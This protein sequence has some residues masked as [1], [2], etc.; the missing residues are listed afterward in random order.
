VSKQYFGTI[1]SAGRILSGM[2]CQDIDRPTEYMIH[3]W[4]D[5]INAMAVLFDGAPCDDGSTELTPRLLFGVAEK[6][7]IFIVDVPEAD[8]E[9]FNSLRANF[10]LTHDGA[11]VGTW[12]NSEGEGGPVRFAPSTAV[13]VNAT[14][15]DDWASFATWANTMRKEKNAGYF[16]GHGSNGFR[17]ETTL[18][19]N[20]Y[21][22][23]DRYCAD[24]LQKFHRHAEAAL[25]ER[26]SLND[27]GDYSML[28]GLAQHFG[29]PTPLLD[30][31]T[32][33]YIAAY[34]A[35][36]DALE[37]RSS[38]PNVDK[39]RIFALTNDFINRSRTDSVVVSYF[40]PYV[41]PLEISYRNNPRL[42]AQQGCFLVSNHC[43]LSALIRGRELVEDSRYLFAADLPVH[44]AAEVLQDLAFMGVSGATLF[45]GLDGVS[46]MLKHEMAFGH[47][48]MEVHTQPTQDPPALIDAD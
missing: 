1:E 33:P 35:F 11:Y 42:Y 28:L 41:S 10:S 17:L 16:R 23:L 4:G 27:G 48:V 26:I 8:R 22:R 30:W 20:G 18:Q 6:G 25:N 7:G 44:L 14:H 47:P 43:N 9:K 29:L 31:S 24:T 13:E 19:R 40:K 38:R 5:E 45:P 3:V 12:T 39:V 32:S 37:N 36:A 34:F 46:R 2:M 15:C 21:H